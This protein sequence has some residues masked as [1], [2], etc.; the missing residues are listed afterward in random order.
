MDLLKK[1]YITI[2]IPTTTDNT[3]CSQIKTSHKYNE[4]N[5]CS[6]IHQILFKYKQLIDV[7][8]EEWDKFKFYTNLY[9]LLNYN[10]FTKYYKPITLYEPISRA[11]FKLW[12]IFTNT[13]LLNNIKEPLTFCALAE[14]PGGFV[15]CFINYRKKKFQGKNDLIYCMTLQK[16]NYCEWKK[17]K[18]FLK[19]KQNKKITIL[20][21]KDKTGNLY[22]IDNIIHLQDS[23]KHKCNL[24]TADGGF[25]YSI[26][27]N[28]QEQLSYHLI[29]CEIVSAF[30]ILK[31]GGYF[32]LKIF[33]IHTN[34]T[35]QMIYLINLYFEKIDILKPFTSRPANSEKYLIC[36][37]FKGISK[38]NLDVL[39]TMVKQ[40]KIISN[41]KLHITNLFTFKIPDYF[42]TILS[43][44]NYYFTRKQI[45]NILHTL[46]II[47]NKN[48]FLKQNKNYYLQKQAIYCICWCEFYNQNINYKSNY[49]SLIQ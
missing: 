15:E 36:T 19:K 2:Q 12:E 34:V 28:K 47:Q 23:I 16:K 49:L 24:V 40:W 44:A 26:D 39:F 45:T 30:A 41:K 46:Y 37:D 18:R 20:Y 48:N 5:F 13:N 14:G 27:F 33:E 25:D 4:I 11:Y 38:S 6:K 29:F 1:H 17:I 7:Y 42:T 43:M 9:E 31:K 22:N 32:I 35:V 8:Y 3:L 10:R 21:G